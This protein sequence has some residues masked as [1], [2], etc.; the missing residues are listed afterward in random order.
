MSLELIL[1]AYTLKTCRHMLVFWQQVNP[2][3]QCAACCAT[4]AC[5]LYVTYPVQA[6][7]FPVQA[8]TTNV[9]KKTAHALGTRTLLPCLP[10]KLAC[11]SYACHCLQTGRAQDGSDE[12]DNTEPT[13]QSPW[14][15]FD[16][17]LDAQQAVQEGPALD[18]PVADRLKHAVQALSAS[19]HFELFVDLLDP[20]AAYPASDTGGTLLSSAVL[21]NPMLSAMTPNLLL[22]AYK[23]TKWSLPAFL[24]GRFISLCYL[25]HLT[26]E[27]LLSSPCLDKLL[28]LG[29]DCY[30]AMMRLS[31]HSRTGIACLTCSVG[32]H[33]SVTISFKGTLARWNC[34]AGALMYYNTM[35][36]LP[37]SLSLVKDRLEQ[38]Y[39]RQVQGVMGDVATIQGN[40]QAFNGEDSQVAEMAAGRPP[41]MLCPCT[42]SLRK[43][44]MTAL[45]WSM[46]EQANGLFA[47]KFQMCCQSKAGWNLN[48]CNACQRIPNLS[49]QVC[50]AAKF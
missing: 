5:R 2:T 35:V 37:M 15:L 27:V 20:D 32:Q 13:H 10:C 36:A 44:S 21:G 31:A 18:S 43:F 25:R 47:S 3:F 24:F 22:L 23:P 38:G 39:Y 8:F 29:L 4:H 6:A 41:V 11:W 26:L 17:G 1:L 33:K 34:Y 40:A 28:A 7:C 14:E 16:E 9:L 50:I 45:A 48:L 49:V 12:D 42:R 30:M 46:T 19:E